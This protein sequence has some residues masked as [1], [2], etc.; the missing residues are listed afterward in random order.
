MK[1]QASTTGRLAVEEPDALTVLSSGTGVL[2]AAA[3]YL[4]RPL[5]CRVRQGFVR[6]RTARANQIRGLLGEYGLVVP[7]GIAYVAKRVIVSI[8]KLNR[9]PPSS[10]CFHLV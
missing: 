10:G 9:C 5:H 2:A 8:A 7:Q 4:P 6:A 1:T 3:C